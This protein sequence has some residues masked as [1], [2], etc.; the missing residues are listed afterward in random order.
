[1]TLNL[2]QNSNYNYTNLQKRNLHTRTLI[3]KEGLL[4]VLSFSV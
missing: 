4:D 3:I 2:S 1:M